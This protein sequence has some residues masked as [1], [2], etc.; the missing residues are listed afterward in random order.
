ME[1][2]KDES[3]DL[4]IADPPF[5]INFDGKKKGNYNRDSTKVVT[6]YEEIS[7][8][9]YI[10]FTIEWLGHAK[11]VLKE[12]GT[13]YLFSSWNR[14]WDVLYAISYLG[15]YHHSH[16]TWSK[17]FPVYKRW[18]WVDAQYQIFMLLKY[19]A[20]RRGR[21]KH[22]FNKILTE[23]KTTGEL[24]HY[25]RSDLRFPEVYQKGKKRNATKLPNALIE[26]LILTSSN[27]GDVVLDPF[28]GSGTTAVESIR[29]N[30]KFIGFEINKNARVV[31]ESVVKEVCEKNQ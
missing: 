8:V 9:D 5:G 30:R 11:R 1:R 17:T 7:M 6:G 18:N 19:K 25:P 26:H 28:L 21:P 10:K 16:L 4:I 13:I 22:T 23:N 24:R 14:L 27:E 12:H 29:H 3:V 2:I 15:L 31:I 20:P